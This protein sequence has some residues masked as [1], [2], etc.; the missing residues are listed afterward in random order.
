MHFVWNNVV[1]YQAPCAFE[2]SFWLHISFFLQ[3]CF[4]SISWVGICINI[5]IANLKLWYY[6]FLRSLQKYNCRNYRKLS[7]FPSSLAL[8]SKLDTHLL[9]RYIIRVTFVN[10]HWGMGLCMEM[11]S[12]PRCKYSWCRFTSNSKQDCRLS[13]RISA[14]RSRYDQLQECISWRW[15]VQETRTP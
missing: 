15:E 4:S 2:R 6:L 14:A 12:E 8:L 9:G 1:L 3:M 13:H 5:Y 7:F 10:I 11:A